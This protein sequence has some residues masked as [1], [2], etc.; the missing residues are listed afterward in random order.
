MQRPLIVLTVLIVVLAGGIAVA[1]SPLGSDRFTDVPVGHYADEAIGWAVDQGIT[2]GCGNDEF[3]PDQPVTR[4]Q[5]VTFLK[6]YH[7]NVATVEIEESSELPPFEDRTW[8]TEQYTATITR[9]EI[10]KARQVVGN[11]NMQFRCDDS[12]TLWIIVW[13]EEA[14]TDSAYDRLETY[15]IS[16]R[17]GAEG[18]RDW[19]RLHRSN[20]KYLIWVPTDRLQ[21]IIDTFRQRT[22]DLFVTWTGVPG[23][24]DNVGFNLA[25]WDTHIEP[26][27]EACGY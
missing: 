16:Y 17:I 7:D 5:I 12:T 26:V 15:Q 19:W 3:C 1:L 23:M 6:R 10:V 22:E 2:A 25:G 11:Y 20:D 14:P 27:L 9:Q 24:P 18:G 4:A 8:E 13:G 21:E